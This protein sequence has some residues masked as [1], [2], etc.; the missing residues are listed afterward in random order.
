M[1]DMGRFEERWRRL[2]RAAGA[3]PGPGL[4]PPPTHLARRALAEAAGAAAARPAYWGP[5][6]S[7]A[8]LGA[9]ALL[10]ALALPLWEG[11]LRSAADLGASVSLGDL[12]RP[13]ALPAPPL[14]RAPVLPRPPVVTPA[15]AA[16]AA[17]ATALIHAL[18]F[19]AEVQP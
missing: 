5:R 18:T 6:L 17:G 12:P 3:V 2:A 9:L 10:Y 14:P 19:P 13:P 16:D 11:A 15:V 7:L 4:G 8:P 1:V